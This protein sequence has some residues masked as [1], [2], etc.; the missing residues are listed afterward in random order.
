MRITLNIDDD[1]LKKASEYTGIKEKTE[2][3]RRA[4]KE[5]ICMEAARRLSA[6]GG[7]QPHLRNIPRRRIPR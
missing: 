5:L 6:L 2:L 1:L 4:L 7:T 3:V